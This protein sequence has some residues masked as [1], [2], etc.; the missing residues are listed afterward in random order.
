MSTIDDLAATVRAGMDGNVTSRDVAAAED[1]LTELCRRAGG[2]VLTAPKTATE[3]WALSA[4][5]PEALADAIR[6]GHPVRLD[7][8]DRLARLVAARHAT[9]VEWLMLES[10]AAIALDGPTIAGF[11]TGHG[12]TFGEAVEM[13]ARS[14]EAS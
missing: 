12:E 4:Q 9:I 8:A 13:L 1:A 3:C 6:T 11:L 2:V 14:G 5:T 10:F 7:A